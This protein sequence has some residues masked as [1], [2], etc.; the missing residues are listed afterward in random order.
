MAVV[1]LPADAWL[2]KLFKWRYCL[3]GIVTDLRS[4]WVQGWKATSNKVAVASALLATAGVTNRCKVG[5]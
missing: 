5:G 2:L 1:F 3:T 4:T